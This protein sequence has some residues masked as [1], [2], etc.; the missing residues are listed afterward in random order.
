MKLKEHGL[1]IVGMHCKLLLKTY[2]CRLQRSRNR[3]NIGTYLNCGVS[4]YC[5]F[6]VD[7]CGIIAMVVVLNSIFLTSLS[8][9][10]FLVLIRLCLSSRIFQDFSNFQIDIL[11]GKLQSKFIGFYLKILLTTFGHSLTTFFNFL[12]KFGL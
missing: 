3:S 4:C 7:T 1:R 5:I 10:R 2:W 6:T 9:Y 8:P 11:K 12:S